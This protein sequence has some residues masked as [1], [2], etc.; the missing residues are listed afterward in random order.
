MALGLVLAAPRCGDPGFAQGF[1]PILALDVGH[2]R[3]PSL[4]D[5]AGSLV[6]SQDDG[7]DT[8]MGWF[9]GGG[10]VSERA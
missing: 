10:G 2:P 5:K 9:S 8:W 6:T 4:L 1:C 3:T 7:P